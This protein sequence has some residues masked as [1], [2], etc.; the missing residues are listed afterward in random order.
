[1]N[2][3]VF[4]LVFSAL[5]MAT[6]AAVIVV[7]RA[8]DL[9]TGGDGGCDLREAV[10][11]ANLN[12]ALEDCTAGEDNTLDII[13]IDVN[14]PIQL[15]SE[16][17]VIGS[18]LIGRM[19]TGPKVEI[20][21]GPNSRHFHVNQSD[22]NDDDF[23]IVSL[24]LKDGLRSDYG[25]SI[26]IEDSGKVEIVDSVFENNEAP[27]GGA[28]YAD[29]A[30][31]TEFNIK[32]NHFINNR[33]IDTANIGLG[34]ALAGSNVV[35]GDLLIEQ[36][37]FRNNLADRGGAIYISEGGG[38]N[39]MIRKNRFYGNFANDFGGAM[40]LN[41]LGGGQLYLTEGN[42]FMGNITAGGGGALNGFGNQGS[43]QIEVLNSTFGMNSAD[44]GG[45]I[46]TFGANIQVYA[47]TLAHNSALSAGSQAYQQNAGNTVAFAKS[48]LAYGQLSANCSGN[49]QA[50]LDNIE[51]DGSCGFAANDGNIVADPKLSG[52]TEYNNVNPDIPTLLPGFELT[53][54]SP[55]IDYED[56]SLCWL[57][58]SG[59][60]LNEDQNGQSRDVDGDNDG[61]A[62]CD[63]GALEA[64]AN[65]DLIF[66]DSLGVY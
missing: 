66:A 7:D 15:Q 36:N 13:L 24:H 33:A 35:V 39:I 48:I 50:H 58:P 20:I 62:S 3:L 25:G 55:A 37:L 34:G 23:A 52:L 19:G 40:S 30:L 29:G 16:I 27:D 11:S 51:D 42:V 21:A 44:Q 32:R 1:M 63:L 59:D 28:I 26:L 18:V 45:A 47:S 9:T 8:D 14:Q 49:I 22:A 17:D 61:T 53:A 56:T 60:D 64:P 57:P 54:D 46:S 6:Q 43:T 5:S 41:S 65:T 31:M 38:D 12:F 4:F 10:N 2:K